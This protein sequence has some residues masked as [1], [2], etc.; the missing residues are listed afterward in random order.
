MKKI[1]FQLLDPYDEQPS[2][3]VGKCPSYG[4]ST[5]IY[6]DKYYPDKTGFIHEQSAW[7]CV[8]CGREVKKAS[9]EHVADIPFYIWKPKSS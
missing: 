4:H 1:E 5:F 7:T 2:T 9:K 3:C 8:N 6:R